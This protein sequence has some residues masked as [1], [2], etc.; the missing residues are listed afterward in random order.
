VLGPPDRHESV[1]TE[2]LAAGV[3]VLCEKPLAPTVAAAQ[4]LLAAARSA[5]RQLMLGSK[6]RYAADVR[7]AR[8]LL[9]RDAIGEVL[10][11]EIV[12]CSRV[13]MTRRW[14]GESAR[15]G[16]GV[17]MDNGGHAV[18][19]ARCL[20]GPLTSVQATFAP[21][22][23]PL[24]VEDTVHLQMRT[25]RGALGTCDLSWSLQLP[26]TNFL[27]LH[28]RRGTIEIGWRQSR[29]R[30]NG[31]DWQVLGGGFDKVAAFAAQLTDFATSCARA[32]APQI[33]PADALAAVVAVDTAYRS[34][35][36]QRWL[37]VPSI[38]LP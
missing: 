10:R 16:G 21:R 30:C 24:D 4:R 31:A 1:T 34:A 5:D 35:A 37:D 32:A 15:A 8:D 25:Q 7:A 20:L 6:F 36:E 33:T 2:L 22:V 38:S 19:L 17:L 26:T 18:D 28:G 11:F 13:D 9:Q 29:W 23:Q 27:S 3:H 12:F 14:N